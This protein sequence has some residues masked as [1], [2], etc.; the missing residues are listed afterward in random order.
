[1]LNLFI[2]TYQIQAQ[3]LMCQ[4]YVIYKGIGSINLLIEGWQEVTFIL[5]LKPTLFLELETLFN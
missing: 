5:V 2:N 4:Y 3:T 1:M